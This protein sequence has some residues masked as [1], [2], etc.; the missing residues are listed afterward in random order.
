MPGN[1]VVNRVSHVKKRKEFN[2][3]VKKEKEII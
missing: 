1:S 3:K 2:G